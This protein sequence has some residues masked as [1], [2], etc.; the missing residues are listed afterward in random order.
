MLQ[1]HH[2][3]YIPNTL[4][5]KLTTSFR[6]CDVTCLPGSRFLKHTPADRHVCLLL[7]SGWREVDDVT[8]RTDGKLKQLTQLFGNMKN[9][10]SPDS[11]VIR[12]QP[13]VGG[14]PPVTSAAPSRKSN[15]VKKGIKNFFSLA[16]KFQK[17][18]KR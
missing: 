4:D 16:P 18:L 5:V 13:D 17:T 2:L 6:R 10:R 12:D 9:S 14:N 8:P 7:T 15:V 11:A 3:Q 1:R